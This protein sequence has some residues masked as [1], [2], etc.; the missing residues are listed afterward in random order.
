MMR[1]FLFL[2]FFVNTFIALSQNSNSLPVNNGIDRLVM[3]NGQVNEGKVVGISDDE[4]TFI[5]NNETIEYHIKKKKISKIQ[6]SSG[7]IEQLNSLFVAEDS[8]N[9]HNLVAILPF[10]YVKNGE[11]L[12]NDIMQV[13]AQEELYN[14]MQSHIG[15]MK[16]QQTNLTMKLLDT[17]DVDY[18][19]INDLSMPELANLLKVEY[20][21]KCVLIINEKGYSSYSSSY[22]NGKK[23]KTSV[24]SYTSTYQS[25]HDDF[26]TKVDFKIFNDHGELIYNRVKQSFWQT[27]DV[28][29]LTLKF[30]FKKSP[31]YSKD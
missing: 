29:P 19:N 11:Q 3:I 22:G 24:S 18:N 6:F 16:I 31:F 12:K 2:L 20:I 14:I 30:L 15:V 26:E 10:I 23:N 5:Y 27:Q 7:R 8:S 17:E 1:Y 25:G 9:H 28:Y 4:I 21:I 13:N